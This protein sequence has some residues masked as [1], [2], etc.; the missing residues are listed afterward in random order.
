MISH[1]YNGTFGRCIFR[2]YLKEHMLVSTVACEH[3]K[4]AQR[5]FNITPMGTVV[6]GRLKKWSSMSFSM[7][8]PEELPGYYLCFP[9]HFYKLFS[10]SILQHFSK[11]KKVSLYHTHLKTC[12]WLLTLNE[13]KGKL[14]LAA[15]D[16]CPVFQF[17]DSSHIFPVALLLFMTH[18]PTNGCF[19]ILMRIYNL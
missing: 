11:K 12:L 2:L 5:H 19:S 10:Y 17:T 14:L 8:L 16:T 3:V 7:K 13:P 6:E 4:I 15:C 1:L 9:K 18:V